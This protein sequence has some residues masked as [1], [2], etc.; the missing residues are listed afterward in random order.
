[1]FDVPALPTYSLISVTFRYCAFYSQAVDERYINR[2]KERNMRTAIFLCV[3]V[4][5]IALLPIAATAQPTITIYTDA[6]TY[7]SGDTIEVSLSAQN[8]GEGITVAVYVGLLTPD[9]GIYTAQFDGWREGIEPWIPDKYVPPGFSLDPTPFWSF[10][11]PCSMPPIQQPGAYNFAAVLT[12]A[13]TLDWVTALSLAPFTAGPWSGSDYYVNGE[14]GDDSNDGSEGCPW[15]TITHALA[16]VEGSE[17]G[18]VTIH[19]VAGTYA[20]STNGETFQLHMKSWVSLLGA[21]AETTVLDAEQ[22]ATRVIYCENVNNLT[23]E[24]LTIING[25]RADGGSGGGI[26]CFNSSPS[27]LNNVISGNYA[28]TGGG[29]YCRDGSS[30]TIESNTIVDNSASTAGGI[31]CAESSPMIADNRIVNNTADAAGGI[32][33]WRSTPTIYGNAIVGNLGVTSGGGIFCHVGS[34]TIINNLIAQNS[35]NFGGGL[36]C[37]WGTSPV[38]LHNTIVKNTAVVQGGGI[39]REGP[40]PTIRDCIIWGNGDDLYMCSATYCCIEDDDDGRG[41]IHD[42]P[43]FVTGPLGEYYLH[44]DSLCIDAGSRSAVLS[45]R[46]TQKDGTPDTGT[47]DMGYHYPIP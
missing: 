21:G 43:M 46:T 33:C 11:V 37:D 30:P 24:G 4:A 36:H 8:D 17:A 6:G 16:S 28:T 7:Q 35:A 20:A 47:V 10:D 29:I 5:G 41:N 12:R 32:Y 38:I 39:Y 27:I 2:Q 18:P 42:D 3:I 19:V 13:G 40:T 44:P 25:G 14:T 1:M 45:D 26:Y 31:Y 23:I 9:G 34:A 22:E 15:R